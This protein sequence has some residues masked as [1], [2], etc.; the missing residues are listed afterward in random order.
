MIVESGTARSW[1]VMSINSSHIYA[2]QKMAIFS[3]F[4][5][6][7]SGCQSVPTL[8]AVQTAVV[9]DHKVMIRW[10]DSYFEPCPAAPQLKDGITNGELLKSF[11]AALDS[12]S[13]RQTL[14]NALKKAN[15][16]VDKPSH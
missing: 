8:P 4:L 13:C 12:V 9:V 6:L 11:Y 2:I 14:L 15:D 5:P 3:L 1:H 16:E 10:A 7:F